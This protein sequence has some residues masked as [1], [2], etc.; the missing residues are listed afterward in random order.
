M[1][2]IHNPV[3]EPVVAPAAAAEP[4]PETTSVEAPAAETAEVTEPVV[5]EEAAAPVEEVKPFAEEG[6]L[7]FK[8]PGLIK[9]VFSPQPF[10]STYLNL[11][12]EATI[13]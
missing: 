4:V 13:Q 8:A 10:L 6:V 7:A 5:A 11:R 1:S 2:D 12:D 3:E 9:Y